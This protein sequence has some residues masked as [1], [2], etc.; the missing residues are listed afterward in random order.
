MYPETDVPPIPIPE[1]RI[2][3][4]KIP[5]LIEETVKRYQKLGLGKDLAVLMARSEQRE[6]FNRIVEEFKYVKPAFMAETLIPTMK[7]IQRELKLDTSIVT[8]KQIREIFLALNN[9][10]ISKESVYDLLVDAASAK[11]VNVQKY[12]LISDDE[13][14]AELE[15]IVQQNAGRPFGAIMGQAMQK[16]KGKADGKKIADMLKELT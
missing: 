13:L 8:R 9:R 10:E 2:K 14:R 3:G 16:L 12:M 5:E 1:E 6:F 4:L 7:S 11:G 15:K